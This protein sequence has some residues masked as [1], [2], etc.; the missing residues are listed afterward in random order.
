MVHSAKINMGTN[1]SLFFFFLNMG[2]KK[3]KTCGYKLKLKKKFIG[4][5]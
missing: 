1:Q 4:T 5:K 2:Q 3:I